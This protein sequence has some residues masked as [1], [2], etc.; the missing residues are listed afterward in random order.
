M[1]AN[2]LMP[3]AVLLLFLAAAAQ[4]QSGTPS[5]GW[6][7]ELSMQVKRVG[8]VVPSPDGQWVV[9]QVGTAVMEGET[10]EWRTHI[11]L[12]RADGS[13]SR[14]LTQG[15]QSATAPVWSPD[16][17]WIL[18]TSARSGTRNVWRIPVDG[19]EARQV[20][21]VEGSVGAFSLSPDGASLAFTMTD[22]PSEDEKRR[23]KEKDDARVID[24]DLKMVRLYVMATESGDG[25]RGG[26]AVTPGDYSVADFD[27]APDGRT[28]VFAHAPTARADD[29]YT[30]GDLA[31][32]AVESGRVTPL[33]VSGARESSP[34]YSRDGAWIAFARSDD[35]VTWA[36]RSRVHLI[37]PDGTG[38][39][40][41]HDTFDEQPDI[42]G[43]SANGSSILVSETRGT[44][45]TL[46]ALPVDG[47]L[48]RDL[49]PDDVMVSGVT[50]NASGTHVGFVS[51]TPSTP[52]EAFVSRAAALVPVQVSHAQTVPRAD[53]GRTEVVRWTSADRTPVEGLLTYPVGYREGRRVP[54]LVVVH[55]GP[56]G[57]FTQSFIGT[58]GSYP[59]AAFTAQGFA[60]LRP[61]PR[62]SSGYGRAFR[63]ANYGDWGGGDYQDIMTG[64]DAMVER[65]LAD[66]DRLGVMGWSYGGYMTSWIVSQTDRF[67]AA[68]VG[69]GIPNLM[70]FTGTADVPGFVPDYFGG[71]YWDEPEAWQ[72]HSALFN[73]GGATTPTLIQHGEADERVPVSQAYELRN[74]LA[75]QGVEVS[76]VV[77]PRQPHGIQEPKLLLDAM[78]RNLNWFSRLVQGR[79]P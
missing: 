73:I 12:A 19:G 48:P 59:I 38:E 78:R 34:R 65:G 40:A 15:E 11:H 7:P 52:P 23:Q 70:S 5:P 28:L 26:R 25:E 67:K 42:V 16:G 18:F 47:G 41:L 61:N 20:S 53:V 13:A 22:P 35:P 60:V 1:I 36:F 56:T 69:A 79:I 49:S 27:W 8:S 9:Y 55:G 4:A 14:Q 3:A 71:D 63:Y 39:R 24:A 51:Q 29:N 58:G 21:D 32:V 33:A 44:L 31:L 50:L 45:S 68:S 72:K 64:V 6:T 46:S 74:A 76:M 75:R 30:L 10:S 54:L 66:P 57:V 17:R 37:R 62:G 2:R 43:W 77:Y